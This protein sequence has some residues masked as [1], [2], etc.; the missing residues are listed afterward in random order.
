MTET[1]DWRLETEWESREGDG[2]SV[3]GWLREL[4]QWVGEWESERVSKSGLGS[5]SVRLR[6]WECPTG[7]AERVSGSGSVRLREGDGL[8]GEAERVRGWVRMERQRALN[9][10]KTP[11][12]NWVLETRF[13]GGF[14]M[15]PHQILYCH[16]TN[17][18]KS[19]L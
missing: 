19:S 16:V 10:K 18:W 5:G 9:F 17:N 15:G 2:V 11:I 12:R 1:R 4:W 3:W 8:T 13:L 7:E 14:H 6:E